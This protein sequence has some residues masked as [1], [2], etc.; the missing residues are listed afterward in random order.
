[1]S[2]TVIAATRAEHGVEVTWADQS[3][4]VWPDIWLRHACS[5]EG[6]GRSIKGVRPRFA[7]R[8]GQTQD[9]LAQV[10]EGDLEVNWG[11]GHRSRFDGA[12]LHGHRLSSS[13]RSER[14]RQATTWSSDLA[15]TPS[16]PFEAA[17]I[18]AAARLDL[19]LQV[20]DRG[21]AL[22][23]GVP[24][25]RDRIDEIAEL[26]GQRRITN[27]GGGIYDLESKPNPEI[28]GD[29]SVRLDPHTDE[30]YRI[31]PPAITLFQVVQPAI[32]GGEST[33]VDGL[34][35]AE[36][37]SQESP[38]ALDALTTIPARFH[39]ELDDGHIF[40]LQAM[41]FPRDLHG[42]IS[43]IR[44]NDRCM[45]PVDAPPDDVV[46]FYNAVEVLFDL[47]IEEEET[48][49]L[50]LRAGEMLIF[51]NHRLLHGRRAFDPTSGRH[52]RSFHVDL[53]EYHST[54]R[55]ALRA[56]GRND[57]WL[58]IGAMAHA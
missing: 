8:P 27:Y 9:P 29:M 13:A 11:G 4:D 38:G 50:D 34:R 55:A 56:A 2:T 47:L 20:R 3:H 14:E 31:E 49:E 43:G 48:V 57:E 5:C 18:D 19:L 30:M 22:L 46:R 33:L 36:R 51:N 25:D 28:T 52:V 54:L 26:F 44:F 39:R 37:L 42:T 40:D 41:I 10:V 16:I 12:W 53:D 15:R 45:A 32:E 23:S 58:R 17:R 7:D 6:C 21:F 24:A 35:I 1:M